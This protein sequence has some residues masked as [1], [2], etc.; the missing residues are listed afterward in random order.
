MQRI[1]VERADDEPLCVSNAE[2]DRSAVKKTDAD[3]VI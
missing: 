2:G 1:S 3:F